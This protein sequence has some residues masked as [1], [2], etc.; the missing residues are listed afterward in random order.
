M[1]PPDVAQLNWEKMVLF[2]VYSTELRNDGVEIWSKTR[3]FSGAPPTL[4]TFSKY[5]SE[6]TRSNIEIAGLRVY[7]KTHICEITC[8]WTL[9]LSVGGT[10]NIFG[11]IYS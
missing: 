1:T 9:V 11:H 3:D 6:P 7:K 8:E 5:I 10:Y 2:S 4:E